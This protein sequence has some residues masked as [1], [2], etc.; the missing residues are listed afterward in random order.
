MAQS[1]AG[2]AAPTTGEIAREQAA[3]E[4]WI[5]ALERESLRMLV[6]RTPDVMNELTRKFEAAVI[7]TA[8]AHTHGR[9]IEAAQRLGIGRNTITRKVQELGLEPDDTQE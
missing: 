3:V 7:R 6:A 1:H 4:V 2:A 9:R 5:A 8:L